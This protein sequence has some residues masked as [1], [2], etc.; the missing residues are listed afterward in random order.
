MGQVASAA[1]IYLDANILIRMTE[2]LEEDRLSVR[3][4]LSSYVASGATFITSEL[5]FTEVLVH[6]IRH[7]RQDHIERYNELLS[8]F[9]EPQPV[10]RKV[11]LTA[12]RLR[13]DMPALRTPD[14]IHTATAILANASVLLTGDRGIKTR[15][16]AIEVVYV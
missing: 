1:S 10:S 6:P 2:G 7:K 16:G 12:A 11:L 3:D 8:S 9:V 15:P 14:A 13:A 5:S 4:V